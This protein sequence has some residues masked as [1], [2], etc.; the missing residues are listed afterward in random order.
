[1]K[2]KRRSAVG[3]RR[4]VKKAKVVVVELSMLFKQTNV[5]MVKLSLSVKKLVRFFR[6]F[7][8]LVHGYIR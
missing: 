8:L 1:M 7:D 3:R 2:M 5:V 6:W 4:I